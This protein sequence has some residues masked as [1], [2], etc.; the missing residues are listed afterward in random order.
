MFS[1]RKRTRQLGLA[2]PQ[3]STPSLPNEDSEGCET[4][5]SKQLGR[6]RLPSLHPAESTSIG[7]S[8]R[9]AFVPA[10][11]RLNPGR[12]VSEGSQ[13]PGRCQPVHSGVGEDLDQGERGLHSLTGHSEFVKDG[14]GG[15]T[16]GNNRSF[17]QVHALQPS[18]LEQ[19]APSFCSVSSIFLL[20]VQPNGLSTIF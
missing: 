9:S 10:T 8:A 1:I 17:E 11:I 7:G 14:A 13:K 20:F 19:D 2:T 15:E 3:Q 5:L 16:R 4:V 18:I 12:E 6:S